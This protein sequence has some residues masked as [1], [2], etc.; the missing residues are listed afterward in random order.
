M[1]KKAEAERKAKHVGRRKIGR[2]HVIKASASSKHA[3]SAQKTADKDPNEPKRKNTRKRCVDTANDATGASSTTGKSTEETGAHRSGRL[4]KRKKVSM[5]NV[6]QMPDLVENPESNASTVKD[7]SEPAN[8]R[9]DP[10]PAS[11]CDAAEQ[12][13]KKFTAMNEEDFHSPSPFLNDGDGFYYPEGAEDEF[14]DMDAS[15]AIIEKEIE[16]VEDNVDM[17]TDTASEENKKN[18]PTLV[19]PIKYKVLDEIEKIRAYESFPS[20]T[21][22]TQLKESLIRM[23]GLDGS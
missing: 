1:G 15:F 22:F 4:A 3:T 20:D 10:T 7:D 17:D 14:V 21:P 19:F 16:G 13:I 11:S 18:K 12:L 9:I 23:T 5:T 2:P 8:L 6:P